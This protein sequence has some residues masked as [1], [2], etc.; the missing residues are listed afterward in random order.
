MWCQDLT[1]PPHLTTWAGS[2]RIPVEHM[3]VLM[4]L[5]AAAVSAAHVAGDAA[6]LN[7]AAVKPCAALV[8]LLRVDCDCML[9]AGPCSLIHVD[10]A[11]GRPFHC[12]RSMLEEEGGG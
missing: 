12:L 3:E 5:V 7:C 11:E 4:K 1:D 6:V 9:I 2:F 10:F 8:Q